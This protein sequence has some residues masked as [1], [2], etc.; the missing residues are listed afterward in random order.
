LHTDD[1]DCELG[2]ILCVFNRRAC[3]PG[4]MSRALLAAPPGVTLAFE[5]RLAR[6]ESPDR[7]RQ[8]RRRI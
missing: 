5:I 2:R 1:K 4:L 6:A 8:Q 3:D 7:G